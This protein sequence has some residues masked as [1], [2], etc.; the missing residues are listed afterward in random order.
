MV[1]R[2]KG[3]REERAR[4]REDKERECAARRLVQFIDVV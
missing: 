2:K 1:E 4:A 3:E